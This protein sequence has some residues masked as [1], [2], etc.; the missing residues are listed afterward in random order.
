M[1]TNRIIFLAIGALMLVIVALG[2]VSL[3]Q[4]PEAVSRI[5]GEAAD[6]ARDTISPAAPEGEAPQPPEGAQPSSATYTMA[7]VAAHDSAASCYAAVGGSVYDLTSWI[8]RH[9]G[10]ER[11]ILSLCGTDGTAAFTA[12]H[13]GQARPEQTLASFKIGTLAP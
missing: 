6:V 2:V 11:A 8:S 13:G 4:H 7:D 12:Q 5:G 1:N 10:G 3:V 9:P